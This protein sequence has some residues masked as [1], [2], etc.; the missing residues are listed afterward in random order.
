MV[1]MTALIPQT[2]FALAVCIE[3][4]DFIGMAVASLYYWTGPLLY[5]PLQYFTLHAFSGVV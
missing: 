3:I 2:K 1:S 4:T 5:N